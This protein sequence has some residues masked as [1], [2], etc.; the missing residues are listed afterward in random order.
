M[1]GETGPKRIGEKQER[2]RHLIREIVDGIHRKTQTI[3]FDAP[4][5]L[6]REDRC[7]KA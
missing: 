1:T 6:H 3:R 2:E 7:V 4:D 5:R